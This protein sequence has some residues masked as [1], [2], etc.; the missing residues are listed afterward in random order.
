M[1]ANVQLP[2]SDILIESKI[3]S[4]TLNYDPQYFGE[5]GE[6]WTI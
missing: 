3:I 6:R 1:F 4:V 2:F 5:T